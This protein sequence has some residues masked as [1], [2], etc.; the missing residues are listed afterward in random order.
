MICAPPIV[1]RQSRR[2]NCREVQTQNT[3]A[4]PGSEMF[5]HLLSREFEHAGAGFCFDMIERL[6]PLGHV[7]KVYE[8]GRSR[9][10]ICRCAQER[11]NPREWEQHELDRFWSYVQKIESGCWLWTGRV[12]RFT[13]Y[14]TF[15]TKDRFYTAHIIAYQIALGTV[16]SG[17]VLDHKCRNHI[18]VNP[19]HLDPCSKGE[20]VLRGEAP[21]AQNARKTHCKRGHP[22]SGE[23]LKSWKAIRADGTETVHRS[24]RACAAICSKQWEKIRSDRRKASK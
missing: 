16:P 11:R 8:S 20:N 12:S 3:F 14:G 21:T 2:S 23:N 5:S 17:K 6:C 22:L 15:S 18:C 24:C 1:L 9:C 4:L 7:K 19:A 10:Q 13:E